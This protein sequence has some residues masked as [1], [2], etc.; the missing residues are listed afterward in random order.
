MARS[1]MPVAV[2][3]ALVLAVD[4]SSSVDAAD[5]RMQMDGIAAGLRNPL[6]AQAIAAGPY[7]QIAFSL[8]QWSNRKSQFIAIPWQSLGSIAELENLARDIENLERHWLPG[9]TGLAAAITFCSLLFEQLS[10]ITQRRVIDVSGDGAD[11]EDG[12]VQRARDDALARGISIN[13]L[14]ILDGSH[15]IEAYYRDNVIGGHDAF[16]LPA[17]DIRA[18]KKAMAQKLMREIET[19]VS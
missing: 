17:P 9:G 3:L 19:R 2:D 1:Q 14:P 7:R 4:C 12:N 10:T 18:F 5:F 13:G 8:V 16:V 6:L 11:N 15:T